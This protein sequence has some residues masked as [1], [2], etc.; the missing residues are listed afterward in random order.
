[1]NLALFA[2]GNGSNVQ[3]IIQAVQN[4]DIS[5]KIACIICD[6]PQAYVIERAKIA[7]IDCF[8]LARQGITR[9]E[10]E[11]QVVAYLQPKQI[12][13]VILA[14]FMRILG[15]TMLEAYP[16]QIINIHPSLLPAFGGTPDAIG[17][18]FRAKVAET[19][20]TIHWVDSGVDTGPIIAQ[21]A[22]TID[23]NWTQDQLANE[24]HKI[25]HQL[26]PK[27]I[28]QIVSQR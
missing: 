23:P 22:L 20:V 25:E 17:D 3:A 1:M 26:Y 7:N 15:N 10:W 18:A 13:L 8:V 28:Q 19:G 12:N 6:Q 24:I 9:T 16:N 11:Q 14:G 27:T 2:S 4:G 5:A 21:Q